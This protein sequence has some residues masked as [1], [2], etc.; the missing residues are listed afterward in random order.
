MSLKG[1]LAVT[2]FGLG[3]RA[4]EIDAASNDPV[5]WLRQQL[6]SAASNA[7]P[8]ESLK[9]SK[10]NLTTALEFRRSNRNERADQNKQREFRRYVRSVSKLE[11]TAR[12][13]FAVSTPNPFHE[14]LVRFWSNHFAVSMK[15][16][17]TRVSA[18]AFEREAIRP[19]ILGQFAD[20]ALD[21]VLH[22]GML[23]YLDNWQS[24]GPN[25]RA[26]RRRR[27]GLNENLA[28]EVLELHTVTPAAGYTQADVTSF[29]EALTGWTV[30]NYRI[31]TE[32]LGEAVFAEPLHEP[33]PK[34]VLSRRYA[35]V[36]RDQAISIIRDLC[37]APHTANNIALKLAR[38][39]V[40]DEPP[41]SLVEKLSN[42]FM[43]TGGDL[44][45]LYETLIEASEA[46]V[47]APMKFKTPDELIVSTGRLVGLR[48]V[49][50]GDPS[51]LFE[52][53]AQIP[54]T[55]PSPEGWPDDAAAWTGPDA[56]MKRIEW[57]NRLA[58]RNSTLD[59]RELLRIGL[60]DRAAAATIQSV[61]RAESPSQAIVL[62][63]M[64]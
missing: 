62:A 51:G 29:A 50:V 6:S 12:T 9:S 36:G 49:L 26:G 5:G 13:T 56:I 64:S 59:A 41:A 43:Q 55:A 44:K 38:H 35:D 34:T 15:N 57:A 23:I 25:S 16:P 53:F 48:R 60:G 2:R 4:H 54:F 20:L 14:R 7:F 47:S 10:E 37:A 39:F 58:E 46:W 30:G 42:D 45:S 22:A 11:L 1:A 21:A 31:A 63:L 61:Q 3:A 8:T 19:N 40:A 24:I 18:G 27:R 52:S 17:Q 33:G 28:R 32:Q